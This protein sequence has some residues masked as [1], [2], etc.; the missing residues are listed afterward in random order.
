MS[1]LFNLGH[2]VTVEDVYS[3]FGCSGNGENCTVEGLGNISIENVSIGDNGNVQIEFGVPDTKEP[4]FTITFDSNN[5]MNAENLYACMPGTGG[6]V[7]ASEVNNLAMSGNNDY[8]TMTY[9]TMT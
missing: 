1:S 4:N 7:F 6:A 9:S 5:P 2:E 3:A 8:M